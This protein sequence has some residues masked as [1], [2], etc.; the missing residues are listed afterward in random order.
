MTDIC[1]ICAEPMIDSIDNINSIDSTK[2]IRL[3]APMENTNFDVCE[4]CYN[5]FN[6]K[7]CKCNEIKKIT[8]FKVYDITFD[9]C[10]TC[11]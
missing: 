8:E 6:K 11:K 2:T 7:C 3:Y 4:C 9:N 5:K 10:K 1:V